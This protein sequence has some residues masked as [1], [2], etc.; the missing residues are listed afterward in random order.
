MNDFKALLS[1]SIFEPETIVGTFVIAA[2]DYTPQVVLPK[3]VA[4]L[5]QE[6]PHLKLIIRGFE[7]DV[8]AAWHPRYNEDALQKWVISLLQVE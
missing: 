8:I 3:L 1:P 2:T 7:F 6:S 4:T 5:R